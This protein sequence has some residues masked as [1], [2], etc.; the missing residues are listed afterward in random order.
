MALVCPHSTARDSVI[1]TTADCLLSHCPQNNQIPHLS[2]EGTHWHSAHHTQRHTRKGRLPE[3]PSTF[4][5]RSLGGW[6]GNAAG[7]TLRL[8]AP[9]YP[10]TAGRLQLPE[11]LRSNTFG[12]LQISAWKEKL[13]D[14][15]ATRADLLKC[16]TLGSLSY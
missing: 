7:L 9:F 12:F 16:I 14:K 3:P 5:V 4:T 2:P 13:K 10:S 11:V 6:L 1:L 15:Q 8:R